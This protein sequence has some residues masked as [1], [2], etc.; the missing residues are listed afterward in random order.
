VNLNR[1][2]P[3]LIALGVC[4]ACATARTFL[5]QP[6]EIAHFCDTAM[7]WWC[8]IR[9]AIIYTYAWHTLGEVALILVVAGVIVRRVSIAAAAMSVGSAALVLYCFEP[10]AIATVSGALLLLRAQAGRD[11]EVD[12]GRAESEAQQHP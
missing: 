4:G 11:G 12:R 1:A 9:M 8:Q 7:P 2:L 3:W 10:G 6:P 5:I